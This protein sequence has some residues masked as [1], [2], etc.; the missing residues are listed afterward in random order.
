MIDPLESL[1]ERIHFEN[2]RRRFS[3]GPF[4]RHLATSSTLILYV[5]SAVTVNLISAGQ[6]R[7]ADFCS[8]SQEMTFS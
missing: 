5:K 3:K 7:R 6:T 8:T 4:A 1:R 2:F